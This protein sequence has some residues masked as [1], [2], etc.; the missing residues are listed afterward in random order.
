MDFADTRAC[1]ITGGQWR[2]VSA[3]FLWWRCF[4]F[5]LQNV[6]TIASG[7]VDILD[8]RV[9]AINVWRFMIKGN[10][11]PAVVWVG[12]CLLPTASLFY[13]TFLCLRGSKKIRNL[14]LALFYRV[15]IRALW[16]V[17]C[18]LCDRLKRQVRTVAFHQPSEGP[19]GSRSWSLPF[20]TVPFLFR[21]R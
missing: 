10:L 4:F 16:C 5:L 6:A 18:V 11:I 15:L 13:F 19:L 8:Y 1:R 9:N 12:V 21:C 14:G 17:K 2:G 7:V 20:I 3:F